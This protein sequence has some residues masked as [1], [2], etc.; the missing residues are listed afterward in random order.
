MFKDYNLWNVEK[1]K[2]DCRTQMNVYYAEREIW[3][4]SVGI[5]IGVEINGKN[6]KFERP[7][8][9]L[10]KFNGLMLWVLPLTTKDKSKSIHYVRVERP[11]I[12]WVS[13]TQIKSISSLRLLRKVC[14]LSNEDFIR[15]NLSIINLLT[16]SKTP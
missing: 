11:T 6:S 9:I 12:A 10:K 1:Q 14:T 2:I 3:W 7:V 5:N 8:L 16:K 15:I 13:L 4:C